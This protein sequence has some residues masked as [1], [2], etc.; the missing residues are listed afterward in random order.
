MSYRF[1]VLSVTFCA[2]FLLGNSTVYAAPLSLGA[3]TAEA[4][5]KQV[6]Q[7]PPPP[8]PVVQPP[9]DTLQQTFTVTSSATPALIHFGVTS[10]GPVYVDLSWNGPPLTVDLTNDAVKGP[11]VSVPGKPSTTRL[12]YNIQ[13]TDIQRGYFW[14]VSVSSATPVSGTIRIISPKADQ[15]IL[16]KAQ[17]S[18]PK[19]VVMPPAAVAASRIGKAGDGIID[20]P[21]PFATPVLQARPGSSS[22]RGGG[23][24]ISRKIISRSTPVTFVPFQLDDVFDMNSGKPLFPVNNATGASS[25]PHPPKMNIK[26]AAR[27][28]SEVAELQRRGVTGASIGSGGTYGLQSG[29]GPFSLSSLV[30]IPRPDGTSLTLPVSAYLKE[31]N[32][33]E[34]GLNA[35][36]A[37]MRDAKTGKISTIPREETIASVAINKDLIRKQRIDIDK[38]VIKGVAQQPWTAADIAAKHL[39]SVSKISGSKLDARNKLIGTAPASPVKTIAAL[40]SPT[41]AARASSLSPSRVSPMQLKSSECELATGTQQEGGHYEEGVVLNVKKFDPAICVVSFEDSTGKIVNQP[42]EE[43]TKLS[44]F[45]IKTKVPSTLGKGPGFLTLRA[46]ALPVG[47]QIPFYVGDVCTVES[48]YPPINMVGSEI[49]LKV[50]RFRGCDVNFRDALSMTSG[51]VP[52]RYVNPNEITLVV[53]S[54]TLGK[55]KIESRLAPAVK[56]ETQPLASSLDFKILVAAAD[57]GGN[58]PPP[59]YF[60]RG[61]KPFNRSSSIPTMLYGDP[62]NIAVDVKAEFSV[63]SKGT[64]PKGGDARDAEEYDNLVWFRGDGVVRGMLFGSDPYEIIG[65]HAK[66][67]I[68]TATS[69]DTK[70]RANFD[71][72]VGDKNTLLGSV[73]IYH[74]RKS[75]DQEDGKTVNTDPQDCD[76]VRADGTCIRDGVNATVQIKYSNTFK[77]LSVDNKAETSFMIGWVPVIARIGFHGEAGAKVRFAISPLQVIGQVAPYVKTTMYAECAVNLVIAKAGM[78]VDM[79]LAELTLDGVG[80]V[81]L[82]F[83]Q[84]AFVTDLYVDYEYNLLN[85]TMYAFVELPGDKRYKLDI[86]NINDLLIQ[87]G[88]DISFLKGHGYLVQP[89][90][91]AISLFP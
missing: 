44:P 22:L 88:V 31:L 23:G 13:P 87:N 45:Q 40:K 72:T 83:G 16:A 53:P 6:P 11:I 71:V 27:Q 9:T 60:T 86:F 20:G 24:D 32:A 81:Y 51:T 75:K 5:L 34:R 70:L 89:Q 37:T 4:P 43:V 79:I 21:I 19:P 57:P 33:L 18:Q 42:G 91:Y 65:A 46:N 74:W 8:A 28:T 62:A 38:R 90:K 64:T 68:P 76:E 17:S 41:M 1:V 66:A 52:N 50:G 61:I 12:T 48:V 29:S 35:H 77:F 58:S 47:S 73:T 78:G 82:D 55:N 67:S 10:P 30:V 7:K 25:L 80:Q 84:M 36:G 85:G 49:T 3:K 56:G 63:S 69:E 59:D 14:T 26:Y 2:V 54:F 39:A 15:A